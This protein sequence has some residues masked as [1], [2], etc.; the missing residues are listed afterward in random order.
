MNT[1]FS[2]PTGLSASL[3]YFSPEKLNNTFLRQDF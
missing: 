3:G 2:R 1:G